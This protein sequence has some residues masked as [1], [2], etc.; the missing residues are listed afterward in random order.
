MKWV[1]SRRIRVNRTATAWL[2]RRFIDE[3]AEFLFVERDQLESVQKDEGAIGFDGPGATYAHRDG[4]GRCSFEALA[5][6]HRPNDGALRTMAAIVHG[7]DFLD[8]LTLTPE[9]AGLRAISQGFTLVAAN[10]GETLEK[11]AFLYDSLYAHLQTRG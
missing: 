10:D 3:R 6:E 11:A 7:A 8:E 2:I 1:T 9:S 4:Q 5:E